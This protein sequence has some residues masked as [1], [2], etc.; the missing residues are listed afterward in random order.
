[1][2]ASGFGRHVA[3]LAGGAGGVPRPYPDGIAARSG[4]MPMT[5]MTR[6]ML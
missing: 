5:A 1:V 3:R 2:L 6:F 4:S